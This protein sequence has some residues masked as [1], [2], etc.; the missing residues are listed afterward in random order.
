MPEP[1][2]ER[3]LRVLPCAKYFSP[4]FAGTAIAQVLKRKG[5]VCITSPAGLELESIAQSA[6][7]RMIEKHEQRVH[8]SL[9]RSI[10]VM[11]KK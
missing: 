2:P 3:N 7:L 8:K 9:T 6:G 11:K 10:Y 4:I 1:N 5:Y